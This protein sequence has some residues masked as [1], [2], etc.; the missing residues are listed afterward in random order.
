MFTSVSPVAPASTAARA[1]IVRSVTFGDSL[2]NTGQL[3]RRAT[4]GRARRSRSRRDR[5]RRSPIDAWRFG[6]LTFTSIATRSSRAGEHLGGARRSRRPCVPTPTR[7]RARRRAQSAGRSCVDPRGD[8]RTL[9]TDRVDHPRRGHVQPRRG[10]ARPRLRTD[11]DFAVTAPSRD[12]SPSRAT[13]SPWPNVPD[14]VTIGFG[15][16]SD[17]SVTRSTTGVT[18]ADGR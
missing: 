18:T 11:T 7:S 12:G 6:Q 5:A 10:L 3:E 13:S 4:D 9:E 2:A 15:S 17:P 1:I 14:A 8:A 16:S